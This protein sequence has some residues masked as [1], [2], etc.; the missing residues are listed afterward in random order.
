M[1][2]KRLLFEFSDEDVCREY[3]IKQ[4]WDG[5]PKCPYCGNKKV[6]YKIEK[7]RRFKCGNSECYKKF[8]VTVGTIF[9]A[10]NIPLTTWFPAMYLI[11]S[12]KKGISSCQL[13]RD[14][15]VTQKTAWFML[16]RIR[17]SLM[18]KNSSLLS[19]MVEVD[20]TYVGG[21]MK[22]KHKKIR[23]KAH[24]ENISH[25]A[26]KTGVMGLLERENNLKLQVLCEDK[27]LKQ[28][29]C[30]N[31]N[32]E[33]VIITDT[34]NA[35]NGLDKLF[36]GHETVNHKEDEF[37]RG[38]FHTNGIEGAFGLFKRM[39]I[40]IYHQTSVKHLSRY[41]D[42]FVYRY[43]SRKISDGERFNFTL[44]RVEGALSYK[45]LTKKI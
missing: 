29:V 26:N 41:C 31:V 44:T 23:D 22:N 15:G 12:H 39:I 38:L 25:T 37:V 43:N 8:S 45:K 36:E 40:G 11:T 34:L 32:P 9:H 13:A 33:A 27:T 1:N 17:E 35:Y 4:R 14:L 10:S 6:I 5:K 19:T 28:Q 7:G 30:E 18:D 24:E 21:K 16:H 3:L 2:L 42:E 20:E